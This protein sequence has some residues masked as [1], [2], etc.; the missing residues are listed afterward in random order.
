MCCG[1]YIAISA[2]NTPFYQ[3]K[4]RIHSEVLEITCAEKLLCMNVLT[5]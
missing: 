5:N 3:I 2:H 4:I 1:C